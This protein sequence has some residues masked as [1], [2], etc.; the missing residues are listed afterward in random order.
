MNHFV[1]SYIAEIDKHT[2]TGVTGLQTKLHSSVSTMRKELETHYKGSHQSSKVKIL[3]VE[4]RIVSA[5]EFQK[6]WQ[7]FSYKRN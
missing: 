7:S 6:L 2:Y 3:I 5:E 4:E 1:I